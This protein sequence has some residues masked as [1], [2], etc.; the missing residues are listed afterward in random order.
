[1]SSTQRQQHAGAAA[2][3]ARRNHT[4]SSLTLARAQA[5]AAYSQ[6]RS[7]EHQPQEGDAPPGTP[8][9]R[10]PN[11]TTTTN[12]QQCFY[13][14]ITARVVQPK[15][16][17]CSHLYRDGRLCIGRLVLPA[18][19]L[20][21]TSYAAQLPCFAWWHA[22]LSI[23]KARRNYETRAHP[24]GVEQRE[25][26]QANLR[27]IVPLLGQKVDSTHH[28]VGRGADVVHQFN[29]L[30]KLSEV[31]GNTREGSRTRGFEDKI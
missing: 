10:Q 25:G 19:L 9:S 26:C 29:P 27:R 1:M 23:M 20:P 8:R 11:R 12:F 5:S 7:R 3:T 16:D 6:L 24:C 17:E 14:I 31:K 21:T 28:G 2:Y 15:R 13:S 30:H 18:R 22:L 4:N